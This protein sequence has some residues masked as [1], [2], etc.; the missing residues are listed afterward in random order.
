MSRI[1]ASCLLVVSYLTV[2]CLA[3]EPILKPGQKTVILGDSNTYGG[4]YI[5]LLETMLTLDQPQTD[6]KLLNLGVPSEGVTGLTEKGH[7]FPRPNVHERLDRVLKYCQ[8]D[9]VLACYG[10]ND[11]VYAP[12]DQ[13]RFEKYQAGIKELVAKVQASGAKLVLVTPPPFEASAFKGK[14]AGPEATEFGYQLAFRD[15]DLVLEKYATWVKS[16][17]NEKLIVIDIYAPIKAEQA[18]SNA[19]FTSDG[20]HFSEPSSQVIAMVLYQQLRNETAE[21][22]AT[23]LKHE[24]LPALRK[25][26]K[27]RQQI[28]RDALLSETK[29]L[30][31]GLAK[32]L[33]INEAETKAA[34][35]RK[36][37]EEK[38]LQPVR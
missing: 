26:I 13:S 11:G 21:N 3:A 18:K 36:Q 15:Y 20:I 37:I 24:N 6:W 35:L 30:R 23:L 29:H 27:Q 31:P 5:E 33:P 4:G 7:P 12:L 28:L 10:M 14:M 22:A 2:Y 1:V 19:K 16:L 17:A 9:L 34:E 25:L 38:L 8:P 32:G